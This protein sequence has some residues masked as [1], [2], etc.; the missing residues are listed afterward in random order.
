ME[1]HNG[2]TCRCVKTTYRWTWYSWR[3]FLYK[4]FWSAMESSTSEQTAWQSMSSSMKNWKIIQAWGPHLICSWHRV[5]NVLGMVILPDKVYWLYD[6][7]V[8]PHRDSQFYKLV[9]QLVDRTGANSTRKEAVSLCS[10]ALQPTT[11]IVTSYNVSLQCGQLKSCLLF[12]YPPR[13]SLHRI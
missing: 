9:H 10:W 4:F 8:I 3:I 5:F 13:L 7:H 1:A 6:R 12:R 11:K 2:S